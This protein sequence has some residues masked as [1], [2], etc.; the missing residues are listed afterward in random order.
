MYI[1]A[2]KYFNSGHMH[3]L[4]LPHV[5]RMNFSNCKLCPRCSTV[6][7]TSLGLGCWLQV[8]SC[9]IIGTSIVTI[10]HHRTTVCTFTIK[11]GHS[12]TSVIKQLPKIHASKLYFHCIFFPKIQI[13]LL[14][15]LIFLSEIL[16]TQG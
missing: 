5:M 4:A 12:C 7:I 2:R 11:V 9:T 16:A 10:V 3:C 14:V 13:S 15:V 6:H 8:R 1:T